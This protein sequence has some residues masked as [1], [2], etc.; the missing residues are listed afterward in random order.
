MVTILRIVRM[1]RTGSAHQVFS[2]YSFSCVCFDLQL[3]GNVKQEKG[4]G[5]QCIL[6]F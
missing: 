3:L 6:K 4:V 5:S 2:Y 1:Y